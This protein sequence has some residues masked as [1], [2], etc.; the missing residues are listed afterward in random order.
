[1]EKQ[2]F[3]DRTQTILHASSS[4]PEIKAAAQDWLDSIGTDREKAAAERYLAE[5]E[6]DV[7]PIDRLIG[8]LNSELGEQIFG[9]KRNFMLK[10]ACD[11]RDLGMPYCICAA[12]NAGGAILDNRDKFLELV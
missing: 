8:L 1:M 3:I 4:C 10:K 9:D 5:L 12:C 11:S 6:E 7:T 2:F